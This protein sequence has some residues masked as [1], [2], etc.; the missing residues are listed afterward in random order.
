MNFSDRLVEFGKEFAMETADRVFAHLPY[1][2]PRPQALQGAKVVAHRGYCGSG[3]KENTLAAFRAAAKAG[4]WGIEFDLRWT[5][6]DIPLVHHDPT[7]LRV[8]NDA[9]ALC[10]HGFTTWRRCLPDIPTFAELLAEFGG[11]AHLMIE[12][13]SVLKPRQ[14][15]ILRELLSAYEPVRDYHFISIHFAALDKL[16]IAPPKACLPIA[17][18]NAPELARLA[19]QNGMGG[20][21]GQYLLVRQSLIEEQ[22]RHG[23]LVG[24]GFVG[25]ERLLYRELGRGVDLIF[26][27][28]SVE[29]MGLIKTG[30][31]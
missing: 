25:S 13:K 27:N 5:K 28:H 18:F 30:N 21:T 1:P 22:H 20:V 10:D 8:W 24:T 31:V 29:I 2:R 19:I 11:K 4:V 26:T 7:P 17:E 16:A 15:D 9:R 3:S 12:L 6:D 23:L 14:A